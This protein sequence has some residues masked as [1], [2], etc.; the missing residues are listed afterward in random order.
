[1]V[2]AVD[3]EEAALSTV[4]TLQPQPTKRKNRRAFFVAL[5][6]FFVANLVVAAVALYS[7]LTRT[8]SVERVNN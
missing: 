5:A 6:L 1:M 2:E 7:S 3:I 4:K 8:A